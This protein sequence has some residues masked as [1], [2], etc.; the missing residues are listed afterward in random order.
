[1]VES[2]SDIERPRNYLSMNR[3]SFHCSN[4]IKKEYSRSYCLISRIAHH[5]VIPHLAR[6]AMIGD[7]NYQLNEVKPVLEMSLETVRPQS[8]TVKIAYGARWHSKT[9]EI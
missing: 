8:L 5:P 4:D 2:E 7:D 3:L 6:N 1:M 9:E